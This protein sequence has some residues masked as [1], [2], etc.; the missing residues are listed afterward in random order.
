[1]RDRVVWLVAGAALVVAWGCRKAPDPPEGEPP[2]DVT[3]FQAFIA[4]E[5]L[6]RPVL[7]PF[8]DEGVA[9][10]DSGEDSCYRLADLTPCDAMSMCVGDVDPSDVPGVVHAE[11]LEYPVEEVQRALMCDDWS[12]LFPSNYS[13]YEIVV[14]ENRDAYL[15][16]ETHFMMRQ[17]QAVVPVLGMEASIVTNLELRRIDDWDGEG[18]PLVIIRGYFPEMP[19][20]NNDNLS[21]T[22]NFSWEVLEPIEGNTRTRR[23]FANWT[24]LTIGSLSAAEAFNIAC[25]QSK[26]A[27]GD[28]D[29]WLQEHPE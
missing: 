11:V 12:E 8:I 18:N 20:T 27:W 15:A 21:M 14:E 17:Y 22:M 29:D 2:G 10:I 1:M 7:Q 24:D 4:D 16:G 25:M 26:A 6:L 23:V 13:S 5:E 19:L 3:L 9:Y 28:I